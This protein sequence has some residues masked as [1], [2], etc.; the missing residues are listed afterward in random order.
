MYIHLNTYL[1]PTYYSISD[2]LL[3]KKLLY[4]EYYKKN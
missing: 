4:H 2:V 3:V 1:R